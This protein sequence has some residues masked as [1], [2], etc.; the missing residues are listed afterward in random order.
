MT[1]DEAWIRRR[2]WIAGGFYGG[3]Y[4][5]PTTGRVLAALQG[6]DKVLCGCGKS[7]PKVWQERTEQTG[8]HIVRFLTPTTAE[9][10][11]IQEADCEHEGRDEDE[12]PDQE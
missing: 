5:C 7:N 3:F 4:L 10:F 1:R 8:V 6:D 11:A 2:A 12:T 9:A